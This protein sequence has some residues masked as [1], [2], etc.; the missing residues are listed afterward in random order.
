MREVVLLDE[1]FS[2]DRIAAEM[3]CEPEV[4]PALATN[5]LTG[6]KPED[7][8]G[9][10][11]QILLENKK[12]HLAG[13]QKIPTDLAEIYLLD[14]FLNQQECERLTTLIKTRLSKLNTRRTDHEKANSFRTNSTCNIGSVYNPF[15]RDID[16]R[17]CRTIGIDASYSEGIQGQY[18]LADQEFKAHTDNFEQNQLASTD[19]RGQRTY[20]FMIYLT[21]V[22]E[23]G[24][25]DFEKL[26]VAIKPKRG[27]ALIWNNLDT[28]GMPNPNTLHHARP[29]IRGSKCTVTQRFWANGAGPAYTKDRPDTTEGLC[30]SRPAVTPLST[31]SGTVDSAGTEASRAESMAICTTVLN[32]GQNFGVWLDYHL[33]RAD[34]V[35]VFMDDPQKR[36]LFEPMTEGKRVL[37][38]DGATDGADRTP[39][40]VMNRQNANTQI[41]INY[42]L[43]RGISWLLHIDGDEI[44]YDI[45]DSRWRTLTNIGHVTFV[46]HEAVPLKHGRADNCFT[47]CTLFKI[48][49][50][51]EFSAYGNGK[52]AVRVTPGVMPCGVH[53]FAGYDG[54]HHNARF[55]MIL[56]Y[57]NPTFEAWVAKFANYGRFSN[58]WFDDASRP[59]SLRFMLE[60]RDQVHAALGSGD[61]DA[62]RRYF[63]AQIPDAATCQQLLAAGALRRYH[64]LR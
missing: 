54:K 39:S 48:N 16:D 12:L 7:Q 20:T 22:E 15:I 40:G 19:T 37:L 3:N 55:P 49:G 17:I 42:V 53:A 41:A 5:P 34:L 11:Q 30:Q 31:V 32:P 59:I 6:Q 43:S 24:E 51:M 4:D 8:E 36:P 9:F 1:S 52:S 2:H 45:G 28:Q 47:D 25:T 33:R 50:R 29:V 60:S 13:A 56:H 26:G 61:W 27:Q 64:P 46:N 35:I 21:D 58:Y 18:Q 62:A 23:G 14:N 57:P 44:F 38:L 10:S 63:D